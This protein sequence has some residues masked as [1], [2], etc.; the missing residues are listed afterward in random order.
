M[1]PPLATESDLIAYG[2]P[3]EASAYLARASQRIR[4]YTRQ[5]ITSGTSTVDLTHPFMLPERPVVSITSIVDQDGTAIDD[6]EVHGQMLAFPWPYPERVTV[7][8]SHGY[9]EVPDTLV[10]LAC[11]IASRIYRTSDAVYSGL[12]TEQTGAEMAVYGADA[13]A[14]ATSLTAE[15]KRTLDMLF[16][17]TRKVPRSVIAL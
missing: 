5:R 10:E 15:E 13:Y 12:R 17:H 3:S 16:P 1:L 4:A 14:G 11:S 2:Y 9:A 7:T 6:Y 8:Y